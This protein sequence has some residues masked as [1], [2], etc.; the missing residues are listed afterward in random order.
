L[1]LFPLHCIASRL[2]PIHFSFHFFALSCD[3][4]L[5]IPV[6][7]FGVPGV[8]LLHSIFPGCHEQ[9]VYK[10]NKRLCDGA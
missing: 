10:E 4:A 1:D 3:T 2:F 5:I 7:Q 9:S 6:R 8:L